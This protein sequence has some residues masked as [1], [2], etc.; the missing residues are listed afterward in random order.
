[1]FFGNGD[2][3]LELTNEIS[4]LAECS[5]EEDNGTDRRWPKVWHKF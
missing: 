4:R 2:L 3:L 1:M 5:Q